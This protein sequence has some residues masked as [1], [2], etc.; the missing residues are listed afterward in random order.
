MQFLTFFI[1]CA[2]STPAFNEPLALPDGKPMIG[3]YYFTHWW[4]P[5]KSDDKAILDDFGR[6]RSMDFNTILLDQEWS[7]AIDG[8]WKWVIP[9]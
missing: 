9:M 5:W 3:I 2:V 1:F 8:D 7:Q 4:E 6:L